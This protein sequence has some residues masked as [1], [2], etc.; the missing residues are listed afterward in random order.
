MLCSKT[1]NS[2][3]FLTKPSNIELKNWKLLIKIDLLLMLKLI[4][5]SNSFGMKF[6]LK[7]TLS[8]SYMIKSES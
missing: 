6:I 8:S 1:S 3:K 4:N 7:S 2:P 5:V